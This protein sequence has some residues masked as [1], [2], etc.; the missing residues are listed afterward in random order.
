MSPFYLC[1]H[2]QF[3]E[4]DV[5]L[6]PGASNKETLSY[7][8]NCSEYLESSV[9]KKGTQQN[10]ADE[11]FHPFNGK[12]STGVELLYKA[13]IPAALQSESA[14]CV[15]TSHPGVSFHRSPRSSEWSSLPKVCPQTQAPA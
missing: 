6:L 11:E 3:K 2:Q 15:C 1:G 9:H 8:V 5:R 12:L 4:L 14:T 7:F 13:L 10:F